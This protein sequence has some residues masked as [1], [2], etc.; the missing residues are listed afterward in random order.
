MRH[1]EKGE[2]RKE[3]EYNVFG[4]E[5]WALKTIVLFALLAVSRFSG[6]VLTLKEETPL[7]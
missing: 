4:K 2:T 5:A 3:N 6:Y 1:R 7:R